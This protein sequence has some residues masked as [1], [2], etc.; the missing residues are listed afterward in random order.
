M[1]LDLE[2]RYPVEDEAHFFELVN[3]AFSSRRKMI[4]ATVKPWY[5][6]EVIE[7]ALEQIKKAPTSRPEELSL[8]E[9][10]QFYWTVNNLAI[11]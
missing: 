8:Q 9:W 7:R 1:R 3:A 4:K 6:V 11:K 2:K 10:V 5:S